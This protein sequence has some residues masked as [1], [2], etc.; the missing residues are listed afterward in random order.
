M[1]LPIL[2]GSCGRVE[3][4]LLPVNI[5][6]SDGRVVVWSYTAL[7]HNSTVFHLSLIFPSVSW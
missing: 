4:G 2:D 1:L 3:H 6:N 7:G 5:S